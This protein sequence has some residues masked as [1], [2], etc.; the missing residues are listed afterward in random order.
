MPL[1][2]CNSRCRL[3]A[4]AS[5]LPAPCLTRHCPTLPFPH[6]PPLAGPGQA[7]G[8]VGPRGVCVHAARRW[9]L[10]R[11]AGPAGSRPMCLC[12]LAVVLVPPPHMFCIPTVHETVW[13][14]APAST[15][16]TAPALLQVATVKM[17][18]EDFEA[19]E[20]SQVVVQVRH[21]QPGKFRLWEG[22]R[23]HAPVASV[24]PPKGP[25]TLVSYVQSML[26]VAPT[27]RAWLP[28]VS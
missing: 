18:E 15:L 16:P 6:R 7:E 1:T 5:C 11:Q 14:C 28:T 21:A 8:D 19:L 25:C 10:G 24:L 22:D 3:P 17:A 12:C 20:D 23:T 2:A 26:P 13:P 4:I 27:C 9:R